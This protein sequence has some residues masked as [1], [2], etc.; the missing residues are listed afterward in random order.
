MKKQKTREIR[1][2]LHNQESNLLTIVTIV[3]IVSIVALLSVKASV[4]L[5]YYVMLPVPL[6][7][8]TPLNPCTDTANPLYVLLNSL[9]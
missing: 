6:A 2:N 7:L 3:A 1:T 9:L 5:L 8:L 4:Y